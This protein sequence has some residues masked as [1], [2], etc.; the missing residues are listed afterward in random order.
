[1][2]SKC[3]LLFMILDLSEFQQQTGMYL[4]LKT[5]FWNKSAYI[6]QLILNYIWF[7]TKYK[8]HMNIWEGIAQ[9]KKLR[10]QFQPFKYYYS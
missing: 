5:S 8:S 6:P 7:K 9:N 2:V 4:K 1:M 3:K 10:D